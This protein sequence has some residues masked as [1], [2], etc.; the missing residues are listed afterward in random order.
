MDRVG[1]IGLGMMGLTHLDVWSKRGDVLVT[2][3]ADQDKARLSGETVAE[4]NLEG[5]A[6]TAFDYNT[7]KKYTDAYELINDPNI[8][9]VDIC[10]PTHLH[11][12][13]TKVAIDAG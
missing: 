12:K 6:E 1:V 3:I 10:L 13:F 2:A 5:L 8:N 11:L 7:V 9:I 4:A